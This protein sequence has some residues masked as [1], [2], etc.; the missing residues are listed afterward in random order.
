[1]RDGP[2][3]T[4]AV[5]RNVHL[6]YFLSG[7][8]GLAYQILWLRKL[9]L[10]FGSTV[11]AVSTVLTVFFGGLAL[12]SW[13]FGRLID[14]PRWEG[15]GLRWY[16]ALEAGVG[17]YAFLT[18]PLFDA[19]QRLYL[20]AYEASGF[21]PA[22]LVGSAFACSAAILLVPTTLLGGTFPVLSRFLIRSGE[23]RGPAIAALYAVN[24][25]G[26]MAGT[27][28]VYY[29]GL[30]IL[31][32]F[33]TLACAGVL[34]IWV[35]LLCL[36]FDRHLA[37]LG[38][39]APR[40]AGPAPAAPSR[41]PLGPLRWVFWAFALSGF[42]AMV[43]EVTWTRALSLV[44][45]SSIYAFCL[46]LATFLGGIALGSA[47]TR[48]DLRTRPATMERF[49]GLEL[50]LGGYGLL[51]VRLF[52]QLP[53][54]FV[55]LWPMTG[56]TF[57]GL[58]WLQ[59]TLSALVML[60]PTLIMGVLFPVVS[61]LVT[62]RF[63]QLG[64]RLGAAYAVNTAGGILGSFLAGFVLIPWLGLPWA[65]V[66]AALVNLLAAALL[67]VR[68]E[69]R[70]TVPVRIGL[71]GLLLAHA[72]GLAAFGIVPAWQQHA[73]AA[74]VYLYADQLQQAP[75]QEGA[76]AQLIYYRDGL[77]ATVS[78]HRDADTIFLRVG[79][80]TDASN[81]VDMGTQ[82]LAAHVP[83]LLHPDPRRVL[84]IG[85]GSG[86][87]VGHAARH[88]VS[89]VHCAEIEPAVIEGAR[90]FKEENYGVHEDPKVSLVAA[91]G[92]NFL[93]AT[94]QEY[95]VI[96]SEP[97]NPWMAGV[98]ALFT[99]EFYA[100]AKRRLAPDGVMCQ[101]LQLYGLFPRDV[102]LMLKTFHE[103]FPHV[104][105]WSPMP[106]D[107]LL[108]GSMAPQQVAYRELAE[109]MARPAIR[110][111]LAVVHAERPDVL[112]QLFWLGTRE[113]EAVTADIGWVHEDDQP[114]IEFN[115]PK[116][117]YAGG[118][119]RLNSEG[120]QRFK[121]APQALVSDYQPADEDAEFHRALATLWSFRRQEP[122]ALEALERAAALDP[123]SSETWTR[124]GTLA[125]EQQRLLKAQEALLNAIRIDPARA[126]AYR[127]LARLS[128]QQ[129][130]LDEA[131]VFYRR[132]ISL[133]PADGA[134]VADMGHFLREAGEP[135][136]AAECYRSAMSLGGGDRPAFLREYGRALNEL[137]VW[138]L[139]EQLAQLAM[140]R[141]PADAAFPLLLGEMRLGQER[142]QEAE[143]LLAR[144]VELNPGSAEAY[145]GLGRAALT[146]GAR[147]EAT[148]WFK[149]ALAQDPYHH[150]AAQ[151][152]YDTLH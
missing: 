150:Q 103:A 44:L 131:G 10:V 86:V 15:T 119:L 2:R 38:W 145:Y 40:A 56:R 136:L 25:A 68:F 5:L 19:M 52:S 125:F 76:G 139:G 105:V 127:L 18:L 151:G 23:E 72:A 66:A 48:R 147:A 118:A 102:K 81:G 152:L 133:E 143:P 107:L 110:E 92:R 43:Y 89:L 101:W 22:V 24:T 87:T 8:L 123:S 51:S 46:M 111:S 53:D 65:I 112:L 115:A 99:R 78:V 138:E 109:R 42:S 54:L 132:A 28:L 94:R 97:S 63:S 49:I 148:R 61:D 55:S 77:N 108:V 120:L 84:V 130:R 62:T 122:K 60:P 50:M 144:A 116:S 45:G 75:A 31:G 13:F 146:K 135:A 57:T 41:E 113:V 14:R 137:Q 79:G 129:G 27:V 12:G 121:V 93:R 100:L 30:P 124:V 67:Y 73:F 82:V 33:R 74:G 88:P 117:L 1:M 9:L 26:A 47:L 71:S 6:C 80:K 141:F 16:A 35:G 149:H 140:R 32:L 134:F 21:S 34:N 58:S 98:A 3:E 104:S 39:T 91:D 142:W 36:V 128:K 83:L 59:V 70:R 95:D 17:L 106:G 29:V 37:T 69:P 20:P 90:Y 85:L 96:I 7:A 64:E 11:H 114:S 126:E 4:A